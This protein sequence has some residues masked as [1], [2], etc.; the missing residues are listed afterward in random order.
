[1]GSSKTTPVASTDSAPEAVQEEE[2]TAAIVTE[3]PKREPT[4][5]ERYQEDHSTG[6]VYNKM[7]A[8][9]MDEVNPKLK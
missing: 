4:L 5:E 1:M 2:K 7:F 8:R 9:A 3:M 6:T